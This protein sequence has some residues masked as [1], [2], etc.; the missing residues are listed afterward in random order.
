MSWTDF[1]ESSTVPLAV[2]EPDQA[3]GSMK[4]RMYSSRMRTVHCSSRLLGGGVTAWGG[5]VCP[6]RGGSS[7]GDVS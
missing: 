7:R 4:T 5:G 1:K 2:S 6:G 3:K